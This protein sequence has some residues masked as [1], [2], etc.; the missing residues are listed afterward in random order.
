MNTPPVPTHESAH[1]RMTP[2]LDP[3]NRPQIDIVQ[4][5]P[6]SMNIYGDWGNTLT[7][8]RRLQWYGFQ[9][10]IHNYNQGDNLPKNADIIVGGGGQDSGQRA[11][12][13]DLRHRGG[14]LREQANDG[15]P[16]LVVCGLYQLFGREFRTYDGPTLEGIGVFD[17][18][19][20]G[21]KDRLIGNIVEESEEFGTIIGYENHSGY[22]F[23]ASGTHPLAHVSLGD[24][25]NTHDDTEGARVHNVIG[26]YVHGALLPK[27]PHLADFLILTALQRR[28]NIDALDAEQIPQSVRDNTDAARTIAL[29][30]PR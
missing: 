22:T 23:L 1:T 14:W 11:V 13:D 5:Y 7:I 6:Q 12:H 26:T 19:T 10:I 8:M 3:Q 4:L 18:E 30:R 20:V 21:H 9:P 27:N 17:A 28:Y 16:M 2:P 15:T 24:G 25:N 29:H